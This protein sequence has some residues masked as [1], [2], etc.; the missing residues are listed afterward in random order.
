[1]TDR[2][3]EAII[4][5]DYLYS[6]KISFA[7]AMARERPRSFL[8]HNGQKQTEVFFNELIKSSKRLA[9]KRTVEKRVNLAIDVKSIFK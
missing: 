5:L 2:F 3:T 8:G 6:L 9:A 4:F 1:M 7:K